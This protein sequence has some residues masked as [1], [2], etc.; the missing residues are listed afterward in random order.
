MTDCPSGPDVPKAAKRAPTI[1]DII[2][3]KSVRKLVMLTA[4]DAPGTRIAEAGGVDMILVGDSVAMAV[5]GR[6]DTNSMT[7]D[8]MLHHARAVSSASRGALVV[9]DMPFLSYE[10]GPEDALRN[11]GRFFREAGIRAVKLEGGRQILPQV[12]A[13][14]QA[15]IPVMGHLGLTPQRAAMFGGFKAQARSADA[16][17]NLLQD[18]LALEDAGCFSI[19]LE[20]VPAPV[21]A[22]VTARLRIPTIGIGAGPDCDGQVL[23]FHD[24]LGLSDFHPRF[25]KVYAD[26]AR[27]ASEAVSAYAREV[28]EGSFPAPEHGFSIRP[29]EWERWQALLRTGSAADDGE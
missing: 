14:T 23:V 18:A 21:A 26:L 25:A 1:V 17:H 6:P 29:E 8:E 16:A 4:Y 5:L 27:V 13:L 3:A 2:N 11:A 24:L 10:S 9:A 19:V 15:G 7:M 20:C 12:R 22:A 28:R